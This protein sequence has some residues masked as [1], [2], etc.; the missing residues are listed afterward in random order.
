MEKGTGNVPN[1]NLVLEEKKNYKLS[2]SMKAELLR[3][4]NVE[5]SNQ[6][7]VEYISNKYGV[8]LSTQYISQI[9]KK[10]MLQQLSYYNKELEKVLVKKTRIQ[11]NLLDIQDRLVI[12]IKNIIANTDMNIKEIG[13]LLTIAHRVYTEN[14]ALHREKNTID[15][16][17]KKEAYG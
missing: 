4:V 8:G 13:N 17:I 15:T 14:Q 2:P 7:V 3:Y 6:K 11:N 1:Q 10:A 9:R 12:Q 16:N 5:P